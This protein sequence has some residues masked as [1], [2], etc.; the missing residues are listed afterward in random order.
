M[1]PKPLPADS[2]DPERIRER[3]ASIH[4]ALASC[5]LRVLVV[6]AT[7]QCNLACVF[8]GMHSREL[9]A[10]RY[11][12]GRQAKPR[13]PMTLQLFR[14]VVDKCR[15]SEPLRV[16]YLHGNGEPLL[17]PALPDMVALASQAAIA[18]EI[19]LVTNGVL[20][21]PARLAT[22]ARAGL[23][24]VRVSLDAVSPDRYRAVKGADRCHQVLDNIDGC[25][26]LIRSE[27]LPVRLALLCSESRGADDPLNGEPARIQDR[28]QARIQ[29]LPQVTITA[30]VIFNWV[31]SVKRL[32]DGGPFRRPAPCEQPFYL[33][34]VHADGDISMC[35]AD[36]RKD[37]V[38][39]NIRQIGG[40]AEVLA[41]E[42]LNGRRRAL[43][44]QDFS[45]IPACACCEVYSFVDQALLDDCD[46]LLRLLPGHPPPAPAPVQ[47]AGAGMPEDPR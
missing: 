45:T 41:S 22:L 28:Y 35:C 31:D 5:T 30:R 24:A 37:L 2:C 42:A 19:V 43:L 23:T 14:E 36:T 26:D 3:L 40:L 29:D 39:A 15:G 13:G 32:T 27:R 12:Q 18:Q 9:A 25:I 4:Q 44:L 1:P 8:C 10:G 34:M 38:V 20:L 6:E 33:L 11:A 46:A 7:P 47:A 21:T 17:N 16:L